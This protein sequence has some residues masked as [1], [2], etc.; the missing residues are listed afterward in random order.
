MG[1]FRRDKQEQCAQATIVR[2]DPTTPL[3]SIAPEDYGKTSSGV[4]ITDELV[5]EYVE[6]FE[7][8]PDS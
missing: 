4:P 7:G 6:R 5:E 2:W 8:E 3:T 1:L